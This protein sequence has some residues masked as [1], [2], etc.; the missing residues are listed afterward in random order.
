MD[1]ENPKVSV[2][3]CAYTMER[4]RDIQEAVQSVL[5]QTLKPYE[6]IIAVD[7]NEELFQELK[8]E[9]PPEV[10]VVL[11]KGA[12]GLSETRNVGIQASTG[13]ITAFID[14]DAVAERDWLENLTRHFHEPM[15]V[16]VGGRAIPLWL[17]GSRPSWFPEELD[18]IAGCTYKG[19]PVFGNE[20][21]N[22]PGCNM[23][24]RKKIFEKVGFFRS[25]MGGIK[26]TPRGGEEADLCLRIKHKMPEALIIYQP[27]A[28]IHHKVPSWRLSLR[29]LAQ[30]SYNEGFYKRRLKKLCGDLC[31]KPLSTENSYLHYLLLAAIP[32]RLRK[33]YKRGSLSQAGVIM[34]SIAA[35]G[36]G[37]LMESLLIKED[38]R[39]IY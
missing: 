15:V 9:L 19:L 16:A 38:I 39:G 34:V 27:D 3:I 11:N 25:E 17:N 8:T 18:W 31:Q 10:K 30:R 7:N 21:R 37:Y 26:E 22:V 1:K 23:A 6:V 28:V 33:F 32:Q 29:Y 12:Q 14:D 5:A 36:M 20:I 24:F 2:I 35:V 4:L 13:K